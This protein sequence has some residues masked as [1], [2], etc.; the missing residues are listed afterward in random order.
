[1]FG[2]TSENVTVGVVDADGEARTPAQQRQ[3]RKRW[4]AIG[5]TTVGAAGF[6]AFMTTLYEGARNLEAQGGFCASGGPYVIQ[7]QCTTGE[8]QQL[9]A[10]IIGIMVFGAIYVGLT[11]YAD[12]PVLVPS[13][14]L[15]AALFGSLGAGFLIAPKGVGGGSNLFV[16]VMFLVMAA[17]GLWPAISQGLDWIKRGGE[18]ERDTTFDKVPL[19]R[20]AVAPPPMNTPIVGDASQPNRPIVPRRLVIPPK[21]VS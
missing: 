12:G 11:A 9:L 20:A 8:T 13:G 21:D 19:V 15:W 6:S 17:C 4:Y 18:P 16:G 2:G 14:L 7:H 3:N 10:G 1:M 5:G